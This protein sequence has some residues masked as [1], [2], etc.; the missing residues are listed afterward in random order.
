M[1][2][3]DDLVADAA[4]ARAAL[5]CLA[6]ATSTIDDPRGVYAVLCDLSAAA[7]SLSQTLHQLAAVHDRPQRKAAWV[8]D[9]SRTAR[10]AAY[11]VSWDLHRAGEMLKTVTSTI[12][13]ALEA[14]GSIVY[15]RRD[16]PRA[17]NATP[18]A[19]GRGL[20]L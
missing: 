13:D 15:Q 2:T 11:H 10:A 9:D 19:P 5:R 8:P 3:F 6:H 12:D 18:A 20:G 14:E 16:I 7:A 17:D 4:E 1:P